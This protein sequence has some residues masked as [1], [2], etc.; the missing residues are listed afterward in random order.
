MATYKTLTSW[1]E[2]I[3]TW[4]FAPSLVGLFALFFMGLERLMAIP[5]GL[6]AAGVIGLFVIYV[7]RFFIKWE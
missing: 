5:M 6:L 1:S 2:R 3:I 4:V 7:W